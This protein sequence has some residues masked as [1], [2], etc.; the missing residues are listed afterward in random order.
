MGKSALST[1]ELYSLDIAVRTLLRDPRWGYGTY[2]VGTAATQETYRDVDVRTILPDDEFDAVFG[3]RPHL[4]STFCFLA[5]EWLARQTG[6]PID[7]QVQRQSDA[8]AKHPGPRN[9]LGIG[10]YYAGAGDAT[11]WDI[12]ICSHSATD[13]HVGCLKHDCD[14]ENFVSEEGR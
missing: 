2:L 3:G 8:N 10:R 13:H 5:A 1:R 7:Y 11:S 12:C 14:C 9:A 6:L 4:W